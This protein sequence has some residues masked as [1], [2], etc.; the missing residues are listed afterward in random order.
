MLRPASGDPIT[1]ARNV[2]VHRPT[3][4]PPLLTTLGVV[5]ALAV[6]AACGS[7][8][9]SDEAEFGSGP[10]AP[11]STVAPVDTP[12]PTTTPDSDPTTPPSTTTDAAPAP[13]TAP[14]APTGPLPEPSIDLATIGT[15]DQ[16]VELAWRV[17]DTRLYV[18]EQPGRVRAVTD[19]SD[20]V[21][22]DL[23]DLTT[24]RG[25][26]GLLGLAFHGSEPLAYVN[27]ID[28]DGDTVV[29][30]LRVDADGRFDRSTLREV[31]T[32]DQPFGN[33]NGGEL[34][35]GPDE[36]LYIGTGDGGSANDPERASL[37]LSSRLGKILR[38]DPTPSDGAPFTVP[39]DNPF[40][41]VPGA[42]PTIWSYGLR[43]PWRF[44]FD[45]A[46]GDLWIADV[47]QNAFE[48]I[49]QAPATNEGAGRALNFGWSAFEG[50]ER[51][52]SDQPVDGH[53]PPR[54]VYDHSGGRCSISG[55]AVA[56]GDAVP[57][58]SGWY[59][60]G[61]FCSGDIWA[62]D[63]TTDPSEPRVFPV[64]QLTNVVAIAEGPERELYAISNNGTV[65]RVIAA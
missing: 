64:A 17:G 50:F 54:F 57:D 43:N 24:A 11:T 65:A 4:R 22:L 49:S 42:D 28:S 2:G 46:T 59:V 15:F 12:A 53:T 44:S 58:L 38:I 39:A 32:V 23:T 25:E 36:M 56:R 9:G 60:F 35:V 5:A 29:A 61:D 47:G 1:R 48:E 51:F 7:D 52:N 40:V 31:L 14:L 26:Q 6:M 63:T 27:Y 33:H 18:V 62:L 19:L 41:D 20:D 21:V 8:G 37:D 13:T 55:G 16:P 34:V 45:V 10:S 30:E 3:S